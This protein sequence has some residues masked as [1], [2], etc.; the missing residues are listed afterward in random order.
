MHAV[1]IRADRHL[2]VTLSEQ[3]PMGAGFVLAQLIGSQGRVVLPHEGAIRVTT[4][5][6]GRNLVPFDLPT[7]AGGLAH[8]VKIGLR[9]IAAVAT[10]AVQPFLRINVSC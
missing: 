9:G 4:S 1:A 5:A 8:G 3:L 7:E 6:E 2:C 10:G